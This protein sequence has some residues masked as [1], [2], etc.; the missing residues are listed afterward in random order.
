M[1]YEIM[2]VQHGTP[3][4]EQL[5]AFIRDFSWA[6]VKEHLL[7]SLENW[8]CE[9][10]ESF[11]AAVHNG[12]II[13]MASLLKEDYYPLPEIYPWISSI[14]VSEAY[15]GQGVCGKMIDCI[16]SYSKKLGFQRTYIPSI[17][18]GLYEKY[19][20]TYLKDIVNYSGETDRLYAKELI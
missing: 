16:N 1:E 14:F 5:K 7:Y 17:H 19:G 13:G 18:T 11:F 6:E 3:L 15:R 12:Q 9:E 10:W 20:Y 2:R 4:Y 8:E